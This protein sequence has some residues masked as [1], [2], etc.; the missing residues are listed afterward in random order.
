MCTY[1]AEIKA[2]YR[3][4]KKETSRIARKSYE[5][6][7]D[8]LKEDNIDEFLD[9]INI[10]T[11]DLNSVTQST[12]ELIRIVRNN[13]CELSKEEAKELLGLSHPIL[14]KMQLLHTKLIASPLYRGMTTSVELYSDAMSDFEELCQDLQTF[15]VELNQNE[16]YQQTLQQLNEMLKI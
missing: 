1:I 13:F 12:N 11:R 4:V 10:I 6:P 7:V 15:R 3:E 2:S 14:S 16:D 8:T 9:A 5:N